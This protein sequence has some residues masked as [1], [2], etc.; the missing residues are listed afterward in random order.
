MPNFWLP[1]AA[2]LSIYRYLKVPPHA[3]PPPVIPNHLTRRAPDR[4]EEAILLCEPVKAVV[5]LSHGTNEAGDGVDLVVTG[6][7][8]VL[9]NL[10]DAQLDRGMV[11]GPDDA[12]GSRLEGVSIAAHD[13][14][15]FLTGTHA[16][17]GDVD[18]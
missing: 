3:I 7:T 18:C 17:A 11:L 13:S 14:V 9:V 15:T 12:S 4:L 6:V 10:A 2:F 5:G 8:A 16:F 1:S